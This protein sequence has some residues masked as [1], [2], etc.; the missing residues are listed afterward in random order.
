MEFSEAT[1]KE[2]KELR[3]FDRDC[4]FF[5]FGAT[6]VNICWIVGMLLAGKF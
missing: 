5:G 6:F 3:R 1:K 4:A 2:L